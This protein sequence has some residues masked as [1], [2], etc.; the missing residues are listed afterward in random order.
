MQ[1]FLCIDRIMQE[2]MEPRIL[3][4]LGKTVEVMMAKRIKKLLTSNTVHFCILILHFDVYL[5]NNIEQDELIEDTAS[6][7]KQNKK[8]VA[9]THYLSKHS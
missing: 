1:R 4:V 5:D 8:A 7:S 3:K 9:C 2:K 6:S